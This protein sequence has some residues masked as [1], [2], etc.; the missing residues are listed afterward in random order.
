MPKKGGW[1]N[2]S[3]AFLR[4]DLDLEISCLEMLDDSFES[5]HVC[6]TG[7]EEDTKIVRITFEE[8]S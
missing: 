5:L 6:F 7:I 2:S 3:I 4:V 1:L 8:L